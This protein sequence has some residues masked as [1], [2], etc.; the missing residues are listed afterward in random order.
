LEYLEP[1]GERY[2]FVSD[3]DAVR[4]LLTR[5]LARAAD[6]VGDDVEL[7]WAE[8]SWVLATAPVDSSADRLQELLADLAEVAI[9]LEQGQ[10]AHT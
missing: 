7:L 6:A 8:E 3:A 1:V 5:R 4:P 2:A 9:A 10:N